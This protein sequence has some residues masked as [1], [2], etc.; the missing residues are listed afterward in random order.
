MTD[1]RG[2]IFCSCKGDTS[3]IMLEACYPDQTDSFGFGSL[4][5]W[6]RGRVA[7]VVSLVK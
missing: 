5:R 1:F 4:S 7:F 3:L 2:F 6:E